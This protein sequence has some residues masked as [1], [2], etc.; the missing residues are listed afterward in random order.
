MLRP[1]RNGMGLTVTSLIICIQVYTTVQESTK[2][3]PFLLY[4]RDPWLPTGSVLDGVEPAYLV[5]TDIQS[6]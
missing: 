6:F 3:S 4:G 2:E 5:D 1:G